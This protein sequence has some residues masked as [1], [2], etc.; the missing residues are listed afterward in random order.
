MGD[1]RDVIPIGFDPFGRALL[2]FGT[3]K[4]IDLD[5]KSTSGWQ[6]PDPKP[7]PIDRPPPKRSHPLQ[8]RFRR[9]AV[10]S[11]TARSDFRCALT[12]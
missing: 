7:S 2:T 9:H 8:S 1:V 3:R 12:Q 10:R 5:Q 6:G 11:E 4:F